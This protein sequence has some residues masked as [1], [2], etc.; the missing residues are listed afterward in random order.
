REALHWE[1]KD[2]EIVIQ[3][4]LFITDNCQNT[5]RH[6]SRY[7]R[8]DILTADGDVKD[9]V[10][11]KEKYK[12]FCFIAGTMI[13]T[14][15]GQTPIEEI[16]IGD[17]V[18]TDVGL[19][20]V[21]ASQI[22]GYNRPTLKVTFT[23][24]VELIG[25]P[26]H[27]VFLKNGLK[28]SLD[29]LRYGDIMNVWEDRELMTGKLEEAD[30]CNLGQGFYTERCGKNIMEKSLKDFTFTIR[31]KTNLIMKFLILSFLRLKNTGLNILIPKSVEKGWHIVLERIANFPR[32]WQ[33]GTRVKKAERWHL[34]I[35]RNYGRIDSRVKE[36]VSNV[37][38]NLKQK[39]A[40]IIDFAQISVNQVAAGN[41]ALI[42]NRGN[43]LSVALNS[44]PINTP[45]RKSVRPNAVGVAK[46]EPNSRETVYN[47]TVE[48]R[49]RYYAND[50]LVS[51]CDITR[52]GVMS[53]W[54]YVDTRKQF[55]PETPKI[56]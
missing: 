49:H 29:L 28:I 53:N 13:R 27:K 22:T 44:Q 52:Y 15:K 8:G 41:Q 2:G 34:S 5:I 47:L 3:P 4:K 55:I 9:K 18:E 42:M 10:K 32:K 30:I 25:T 19:R 51:N 36:Y 37:V 54:R 12:D 33:N 14:I 16:K 11:P 48:G 24:G 50:I 6:L 45:S 43:V 17:L 56:Y 1:E 39:S 21:I 23:N 31:M 35:L 46:V 20:K 7:S 40:L 38:K 26:N